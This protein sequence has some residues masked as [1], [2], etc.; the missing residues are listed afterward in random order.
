MTGSGGFLMITRSNTMPVA[1]KAGPD[2][3]VPYTPEGHA[4]SAPA[5]VSAINPLYARLLAPLS[6]HYA[7]TAT[8]EIRLSRPHRVVTDRRGEGKRLVEDDSLSQGTIEKIAK[9]LA[10]ASGLTFDGETTPKLSCI[11]PGGHRFEALVGPSV[12]TGGISL[13]VRCKH[14]FVPA[15]DHL[16]ATPA[17]RD[18][19]ID[20]ARSERNLVISGATNTGKTTLLNMLLAVLDEDRRVVAV[21]DTPELDIER[22]WDGVGLIAAREEGTGSGMMGWRALYDHIMRIT[23]DNIVFGEISTQNAFAALSALNA[24]VT[25]CRMTI[26]AESPAQAI[27]RKF[28]Q[29]VAWSGERMENIPAFLVDLI[30]VVVQIRRRADGYRRITDIWEPKNDRWVLKDG[31][32]CHAR[33]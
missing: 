19:L 12:R 17:I 31:E 14:P 7:D 4:E 23:P 25:G 32:E 9:S 21:E 26:H 15:W 20:V 22:F 24:G 33:Q 13:A 16:G 3:R 18:Y 2:P 28:A 30:D 6:A 1:L 5:K 27:H 29:N 10:N 11:L 8:L